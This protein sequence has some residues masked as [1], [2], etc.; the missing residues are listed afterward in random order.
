MLHGKE[1]GSYIWRSHAA[2]VN[3]NKPQEHVS[4]D[5]QAHIRHRKMHFV[6][7][8]QIII[9]KRRVILFTNN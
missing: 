9:I 2:F 4:F 5:A 7:H 3:Q 8:F 6:V 1:K